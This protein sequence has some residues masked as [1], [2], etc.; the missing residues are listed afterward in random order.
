MLKRGA[1]QG[2]GVREKFW[3]KKVYVMLFMFKTI[4]LDAV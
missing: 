4:F 2:K 3:K 1:L